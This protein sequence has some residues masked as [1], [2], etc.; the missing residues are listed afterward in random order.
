VSEGLSV[1][2]LVSD[3]M[4]SSKISAEARAC[5]VAVMMLRDPAKLEAQAGRM[6]IVDLN[7]AG[8]IAAAGA[9]RK[10]TGR[11]VVGFV[12]HVDAEAIANA[13]DAGIDQIMA[14]SRFVQVLPEL[15]GKQVE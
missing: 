9:W 5:G 2:A 13:R 12:S 8:A 10:A 3:L 4:F 14:R 6:L 7:L 15:F 1:L 11:E